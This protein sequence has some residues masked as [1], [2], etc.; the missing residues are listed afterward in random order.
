MVYYLPGSWIQKTWCSQTLYWPATCKANSLRLSSSYFSPC[1]SSVF[2]LVC[3]GGWLCRKSPSAPN[4]QDHLVWTVG[5]TVSVRL[6]IPHRMFRVMEQIQSSFLGSHVRKWKSILKK[7]Q[8]NKTKDLRHLFFCTT[9]SSVV[10]FKFLSHKHHYL[11]ISL[12]LLQ[13][14]VGPPGMTATLL[15]LQWW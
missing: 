14:G 10:V 4:R 2:P 12:F 8:S 6:E 13:T 3:A 1:L 5:V 9:C 15:V 7:S 11:P